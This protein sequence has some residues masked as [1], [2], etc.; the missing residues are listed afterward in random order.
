VRGTVLYFVISD[1]AL[2]DPMYQFSLT[3]FKKLF[4]TAIE[5]SEVSD[6]L[7]RRL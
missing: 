6:Q 1:L 4:L 2:I 5:N 7:E 3:Y